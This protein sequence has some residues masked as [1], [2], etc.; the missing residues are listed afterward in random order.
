MVALAFS[1]S[2]F[3]YW[4]LVGRAVLALACPRLGVLRP[5]L[6]APGVGLALTIIGTTIV[7]QAGIPLRA[8]TWPLTAGLGLAALT[9]LFRLRTSIPRRPGAPFL[10]A[11]IVCL[12]WTGWPALVSGFK[13]ISYSNDDMANYCLAAERFLAT[14]FYS[15]PTMAELAGRDYA[16]YYYFMHV[17]DMMRHGAEHVVAWAAALGGLKATQ[18]FM[19]AILALTLT[20]LFAAAEIGR[21]HV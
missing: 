12:V 20:Q 16:S 21:A 18:A 3:A 14:G 4:A 2:L 6:L 13:W 9:T 10:L 11:S 1:F 15:V 19:P 7:N 8:G 17:A 5:W